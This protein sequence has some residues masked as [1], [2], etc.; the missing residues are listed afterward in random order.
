MDQRARICYTK[1]NP[2]YPR[3]CKTA[4]YAY[5]QLRKY[6]SVC[7]EIRSIIQH[8]GTW[9]MH[10]DTINYLFENHLCKSITTKFPI[11]Y[12][13]NTL[14]PGR[15]YGTQPRLFTPHIR[16]FSIS[17][18]ILHLFIRVWWI[19][20]SIHSCSII[21]CQKR[22]QY[23]R[24]IR[25]IKSQSEYLMAIILMGLTV[26]KHKWCGTWY[27]IDSIYFTYYFPYNIFNF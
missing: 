21:R 13:S 18:Q 17:M 24:F 22:P 6:E 16:G 15:V 19:P 27:F 5:I 4:L 2:P 11:D 8:L 9:F 20:C 10:P 3:S 26:G 25:F 1:K 23:Q 7:T 12:V 14:S